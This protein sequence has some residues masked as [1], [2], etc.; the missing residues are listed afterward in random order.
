[1]SADAHP[2]AEALL[3]ALKWILRVDWESSARLLRKGARE[4]FPTDDLTVDEAADALG[5]SPQTVRRLLCDGRS[6]GEGSLEEPIR[7]GSESE[8]CLSVPFAA[9]GAWMDPASEGPRARFGGCGS[10][11]PAGVFV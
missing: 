3:L 1:M 5:T 2:L 10:S 4:T 11:V 7:L 6:A 9:G 8:R